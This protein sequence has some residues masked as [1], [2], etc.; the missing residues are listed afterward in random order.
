MQMVEPSCPQS[1]GNP[2]GASE[3]QMLSKSA[4]LKLLIKSKSP[5]PGIHLGV[6]CDSQCIRILT[7]CHHRYSGKT[8]KLEF[9]LEK[10]HQNGTVD[11]L[12]FFPS[13]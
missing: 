7:K 12:A 8:N 5:H 9:S 1:L 4:V 11:Y 6:Q 2:H 10:N 3:T 13:L